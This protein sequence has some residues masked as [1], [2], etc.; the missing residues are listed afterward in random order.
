MS[1]SER[2]S[3]G[4]LSSQF[5]LLMAMACGLCAGSAYFNQ[6]LIYSIE[7]SLGISTSQAGFAVVIAQIGYVLLNAFGSFGRLSE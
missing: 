6:P 1:N 4:P 3:V 5:V 2:K 7:K